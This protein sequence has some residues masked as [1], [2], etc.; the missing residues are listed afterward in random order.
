MITILIIVNFIEGF[1]MKQ[2]LSKLLA[3]S[4]I[5]SPIAAF[6]GENLFGYVVEA[7]VLPKGAKE[8]YLWM[9]HHEGKDTGTSYSADRMRM[10]LEYGLSDV[11][12]MSGYLN[13]YRHSFTNFTENGTAVRADGKT[14]Y[15]SN[16]FKPGGAQLEFKRQFLSAAKDDLGLAIYLEPGYFWIDPV[17]GENIEG[18]ELE[19]KLILQKYWWDGQLVWAGNLTAEYETSRNKT[20]G[21]MIT[22]FSPKVTTGLSYRFTDGWYAGVEAHIDQ[23]IEWSKENG[24]PEVGPK[25]NH[26]DLWAGPTIHYGNKQWWAT[27]TAFSQISGMPAEGA[28]NRNLHLIDHE[29][30]ETRLKIGY[31]F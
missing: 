12:Q 30:N 2:S 6:A 20:D 11:W 14:D 7:D 18:Y 1:Y 4:L 28:Q 27:I 9:T 19:T 3:L 15:D 24:K 23:D 21:S 8:A 31:N 10:E 17:T 22:G 13:A 29:R 26:W 25:V 5:M 16:G